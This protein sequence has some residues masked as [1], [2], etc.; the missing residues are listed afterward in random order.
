V[1]QV[2]RAI[3]AKPPDPNALEERLYVALKMTEA[4][5]KRLGRLLSRQQESVGH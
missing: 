4:H 5:P 2:L 3:E 1:L